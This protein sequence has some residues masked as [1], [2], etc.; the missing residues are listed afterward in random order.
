MTGGD[1]AKIASS[2]WKKGRGKLGALAPL[3]GNW[4]AQ[5]DSPVGPVICMRTFTLILGGKYAQL[6]A[7]WQFAESVYEE[8]A[9]FGVGDDGML[10]FWS[11]TSDGKHAQG[12]I[13]DVT[14]IH[15]Q[16][17]GFEAEMPA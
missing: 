1:M 8:L 5:A 15:P 17:I 10:A 9:L 11:F 13:A 6:A 2:G 3:L 14:D 16:A 4:K 12:R 7:R